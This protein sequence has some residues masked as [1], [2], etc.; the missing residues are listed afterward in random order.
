ET[1]DIVGEVLVRQ[2]DRPTFVKVWIEFLSRGARPPNALT[3]SLVRMLV[4]Q[5]C[6]EQAVW[7]MRISRCLP[8]QGEQLPKSPY[9]KDH[10]PWDLKVQIMYVSAALEAA[11]S[12]DTIAISREDALRQGKS[13]AQLPLLE[14]PDPVMYAQL[15]GGAVR[16]RNDKLAEHLF[17]ELVDAGVAPDNAT[18]G[19]LASLYADKGQ[20]RRVFCIARNMLVH[21]HSLLAQEKIQRG[22]L[23]SL[24]AQANYRERV[25]RQA[26]NL[27]ADVECIVPLLQY[28]IQENSEQEALILLRSWDLN[29]EKRVPA[30]KLANVLLKVYNRPED[31][32]T[33][34]RLLTRLV[35]EPSEGNTGEEEVHKQ[36]DEAA[37]TGCIE[38]ARSRDIESMLRAFSQMIKTHFLAKNLP[39]VVRVLRKMDESK[40]QPSYSVLELVMRGFLREQALDLFDTVHAYVRETLRMPLSL[41]LYSLWMRSLVNHG[42]VVGVQAAFDELLEM[43][44][45]PTHRHYLLLVQAY[46]Y[47]GWVDRAVSIVNNMRSP[48]SVI[49]P[50]LDINTA[51]I[52]A[53]VA[54]GNMEQAEAEL[55]YLLDNTLLPANR[56]PARPFNYMIIG[57]LYYGDGRK[58]MQM[59]EHML[60]LGIKP[61][62]YT[63]S[64]LMHSYAL[65]RDLDNCTRV[66]N[67]MIRVGIAPDL[68]IYTI[69]ICA[70]G[71]AKKV[72]SAELVFNQVAQEQ[73]WAQT[74]H[75]S[76]DAFRIGSPESLAIYTEDPDR[77]DWPELLNALEHGESIQMEKMR[78]SSFVNLDPIIYIAMLKVYN[79]SH[80]PMRALATWD[81]FIRNYPVVHWNPREGGILSKTLRY[82]A[83]FHLPAWTLLLRTAKVSIGVP[84]VLEK[85]STLKRY[86]FVPLYPAE[87]TE[88]MNARRRQKKLLARQLDVLDGGASKTKSVVRDCATRM[89]RRVELVGKL[90][91]E[92]DSRAYYDFDFCRKQRYAAARITPAD[93]DASFKD[94]DY[95]MP[96]VPKVPQEPG[97]SGGAAEPGHISSSNSAENS[98]ERYL[99]SDG[100]FTQETAQGI[101]TTVARQWH[102]L[103]VAGFKFNNIH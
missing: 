40:L 46:A 78:T 16:M 93:L 94:F 18:Y 54:C 66:F 67:E 89:K 7:V 55:R 81:R 13:A 58:A 41:P 63:F 73:E 1:W 53:H 75:K 77:R 80:R 44:Q 71:M 49:R 3:R 20:I 70:F 87:I 84:R 21:Q 68:V 74:Q 62:V 11:T 47:N 27:K 37:P 5:S 24:A 56:I 10:V 4:R 48:H 97:V 34:D 69:L 14:R 98:A 79:K 72:G 26:L 99:K 15:I 100:T 28:Y 91:K 32:T 17:K 52:E 19:H 95:W 43:G 64:I 101:A 103:E 90:E 42:D 31:T 51:I 57:S 86:L 96:E 8:D 92:L 29:Y 12:L 65:A 9:G 59:Y 83:Q 60:R 30:D 85:K 39:G 6:V 76:Q 88:P 2:R 38:A 82:T 36:A 22:Q 61:D 23:G 33:V 45:F 35:E 25:R 50:G 102:E